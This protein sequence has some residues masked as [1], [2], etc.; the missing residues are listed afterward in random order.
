MNRMPHLAAVMMTGVAV[1]S[2]L[3]ACSGSPQVQR[4]LDYEDFSLAP[5]D[6]AT[7]GL[8]FVTPSSITG[9]EQD[10]Q[11]VAFVFAK[12]LREER[13]EIPVVTLA[14]TLSDINAAGM[15]DEYRDMLNHM[16]ATG[17]LPGDGLAKIRQVTGARYVVMLKL[18]SFQSESSRRF[19]FF[20]MRLVTTR[21]A[22]LRL[23]YQI[24]DTETAAIAWEANQEMTLA[25]D[26]VK[27][28]MVTFESMVTHIARD[29]IARMPHPCEDDPSR[30]CPGPSRSPDAASGDSDTDSAVG[31]S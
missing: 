31:G 16:D 24:W 1:L 21:I 26:T 29:L 27:E 7:H 23:F 22:T 28:E 17:V 19:G 18:A 12:V 25:F 9:H 4:A 15:A 11:T 10:R 13:P 14:E 8:A 2:L 5:G 3:A 6:L 30:E 20:S